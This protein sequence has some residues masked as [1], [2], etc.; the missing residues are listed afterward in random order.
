[1]NLR[2]IGVVATIVGS[3]VEAA[4]G[5]TSGALVFWLTLFSAAVMSEADERPAG[6]DRRFM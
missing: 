1:M 4:A 6:E 2:K 3:F 5:S